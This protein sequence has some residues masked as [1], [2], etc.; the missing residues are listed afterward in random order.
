MSNSFY[1]S[2]NYNASIPGKPVSITAT[3]RHNQNSNTGRVDLV[4]PSLGVN[5]SRF[6]LPLSRIFAPNA[7][8]RK[9]YDRIGMTY[10]LKSEQCV[11]GTDSTLF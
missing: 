2:V 10:A 1:S 11:T 3:A 6:E 9:W 7:V 4:V 8:T 5:V